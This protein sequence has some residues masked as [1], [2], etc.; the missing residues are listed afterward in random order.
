MYFE[1]S[2]HLKSHKTKKHFKCEICCKTVKS[3][4]I[5]LRHMRIHT[6]KK[7]YECDLCSA[8]FSDSS[9]KKRHMKT[10]TTKI[11]P[12]K[13]ESVNKIIPSQSL[14]KTSFIGSLDV[15][16]SQIKLLILLS[17][18][19]RKR[20]STEKKDLACDYLWE[21]AKPGRFIEDS[22]SDTKRLRCSSEPVDFTRVCQADSL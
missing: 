17:K 7:P 20:G 6:G 9:N 18:I 16:D 8:S 15:R 3:R 12:D 21:P 4:S 5:L 11:I 2:D 10:H 19:D 14:E 22:I 1:F 13:L